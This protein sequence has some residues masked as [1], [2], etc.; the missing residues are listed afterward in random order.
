[1]T[2][3]FRE[4]TAAS[5]IVGTVTLPTPFKPRDRRFVQ[6]TLR[7]LRRVPPRRSDRS[8]QSKMLV[9]HPVADCPDAARHLAALRRSQRIAHQLEQQ[10]ALQRSGGHGLVEE[11]TVILG[12]LEDLDYV[13]GW[14]LTPRGER[15][16]R[17]YN[18]SDLLLAETIEH[19]ALYGLEPAEMAALLSVFVYEP[20]TE[21][22]SPAEWPTTEL[23]ERW[24]QI[25]GLWSDL[26][27]AER[28][29]R[30]AS[31]RRPDPGFGLL[32][33]LWASGIEFDE[34]PTKGM[35]P[36]DFVRVSRQLV[37]LLRQLRDGISELADDAAQ[38]LRSVD[39]G[40]V[41]A[42]GVG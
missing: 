19:G 13:E 42:Q 38:A 16:R 24:A 31:T 14:K 22:A 3:G 23:Y 33:H 12:L 27:R 32:A 28:S 18:E 37:D 29:G 35:A 6:E 26:T 17:I 7:Q 11:F 39:R 34:L 5:R 41:A 9:E 40:V 36:G 8:P 1:M 10:L 25:E 30:L 4:I 20:R 2:I 21:H 15:L